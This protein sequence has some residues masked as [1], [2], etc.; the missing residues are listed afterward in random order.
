M[1]AVETFL[2]SDRALAVLGLPGFALL[3]MF[4]IYRLLLQRKLITSVSATQS[5]ILLM[6]M[7]TY[8]ALAA[9]VAVVLFRPVDRRHDVAAQTPRPAPPV[10]TPSAGSNAI[11]TAEPAA[12]APPVHPRGEP[13]AEAPQERAHREPASRLR[14]ADRPAREPPAVRDEA[15]VTKQACVI[16]NSNIEAPVMQSCRNISQ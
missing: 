13:A 15:V 14:R 9:I 6:G 5:F 4:L 16:T 7:I 10:T 11:N 2:E 8:V 12:E 3:L 1:Q